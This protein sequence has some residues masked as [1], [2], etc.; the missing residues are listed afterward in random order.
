MIKINNPVRKQYYRIGEAKDIL[1]V[2]DSC[3]RFWL[4]EFEIQVKRTI[5]NQRKIDRN[6]LACLIMIKSLLKEQGF[7][8]EGAKQQLRKA[9][10]I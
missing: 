7:T 3:I 6:S 1:K 8:I 4:D 9:K 2:A 5:G 10:L